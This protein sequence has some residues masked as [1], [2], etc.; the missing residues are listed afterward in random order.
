MKRLS[1]V[2]LNPKV[3][4]VAF[5]LICTLMV[6]G[7]WEMKTEIDALS[8]RNDQYEQQFLRPSQYFLWFQ[9]RRAPAKV[10]KLD[11]PVP[12]AIPANLST[13]ISVL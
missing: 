5:A 2:L 10:P 13:N 6:G 9:S 1:Y 3:H 8:A 12:W 7:A 11:L 4:T